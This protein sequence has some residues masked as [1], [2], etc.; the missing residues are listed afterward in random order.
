MM[1]HQME[2]DMIDF[3]QRSKNVLENYLSDREATITRRQR[4][5]ALLE[6]R[7]HEGVLRL[8]KV[9]KFSA[10]FLA[11]R[12]RIAALANTALDKAIA[13]GDDNVAAIALAID[14]AEYAKDFF[15][16]MNKIGG[17]R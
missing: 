10:D 2:L 12:K 8:N 15:G 17:I 7:C 16:M 9:Q 13:L 5:L 3:L 14:E 1:N 4:E 6:A 11:N